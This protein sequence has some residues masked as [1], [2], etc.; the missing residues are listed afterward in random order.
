MKVAMILGNTV[1]K[2]SLG[3]IVS[4][5]IRAIIKVSRTGTNARCR[6]LN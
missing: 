3:G 5:K 4:T 6:T 2:T 1:F